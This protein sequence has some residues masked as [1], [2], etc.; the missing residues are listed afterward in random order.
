[1]TEL[2][3]WTLR[4]TWAWWTALATWGVLG[5]VYDDESPA[6]EAGLVVLFVVLPA[7]ALAVTVV[8]RWHWRRSVP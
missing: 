1:M 3:P 2:A 7:L 4:L 8:R 5:L 6:Y